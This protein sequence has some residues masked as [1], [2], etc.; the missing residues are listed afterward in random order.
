[1]NDEG[2]IHRAGSLKQSNKAYKS[3]HASKGSIKRKNKGRVDASLPKGNSLK[4]HSM[5][6]EHMSKQQRRS[7]SD[8]LRKQK[9]AAVLHQ[10][11]IGQDGAP[12]IVA[13]LS[14][15]EVADVSTIRELLIK[16]QSGNEG[17][18]VPASHIPF[19]FKLDTFKQRISVFEVQREIRT[20]L[21]AAKVADIIVLVVDAETG[22]D[23]SG[24]FL[25]NLIKGQG[26]PS[27]L[28]ILQNLE[29]LG[30]HK[31]DVK[32]NIMKWIHG[33]LPEEPRIV[34]FDSDKD[35]KQLSRWISEQT[36]KSIQWREKRPYMLIEN[37]EFVPNNAQSSATANDSSLDSLAHENKTGTLVV[38]GY[39]RGKSMTPNQLVN[40]VNYGTYQLS[41]IQ[42]EYDPCSL[43][44][45][46]DYDEKMKT[47][48]VPDPAKQESLQT[49]LQPDTS[50]N[51][52]T[53]PTAEDY[54]QQIEA[55]KLKKV[56]KGFSAY[57]AAWIP[58]DDEEDVEDEDEEDD[59]EMDAEEGHE[60]EQNAENFDFND[61]ASEAQTH[62]DKHFNIDDDEA[63]TEE[64]RLAERERTL[65]MIQ[66]SN[67][68]LEFPD[69]VATPL[70]E[71]ARVRFQK[72]RGLKSFRQSP[73]DSK[74]N[75][76]V[77]YS[78]IFQF[79]NFQRS[80][81]LSMLDPSE[82]GDEPYAEKENY[83]S[84][85]IADVPE[86]LVKTHEMLKNGPLVMFGL[87]RH[88]QKYSVLHF[89][90]K[91]N[92]E[93]TEPIK[94]KDELIVQV[95][96]RMFKC[97]PIYSEHNPRNDKH[98]FER[99]LPASTFLAASV[100]GPVTFRPAPVLM[101]KRNPDA[102]NKLDRLKLVATG[103]LLAVDPDRVM[104]KRI[105]L[106]GHPYKIHKK[107]GVV[108]YMFYNPDDIR[109]FKPVEL[110]TKHGRHGVIRESL[111][112]HG[113]MKCQFDNVVHQYDT[114][115]MNLYKR[116][117]PK[118][119]TEHFSLLYTP[120]S[121]LQAESKQDEMEA[122]E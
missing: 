3:K 29:K 16:G 38:R 119:T 52:Q 117:Y 59:V 49:S 30:K 12:K 48:L 27:S 53:W 55:K 84:F 70:D 102:T 7:R 58:D 77:D 35:V 50:M 31:N 51:E 99:F 108:R 39:L 43:K 90:I 96:F 78:R 62:V 75:L 23:E 71:P 113:L 72:Y 110:Y 5:S 41:K 122:D 112:T 106:T 56:P 68:E 95:G 14:L 109:W 114:I 61:V 81:K 69:E 60:E 42:Y 13:F 1:M 105:I 46:V 40:L 2:T 9:K 89:Q 44:K 32:K 91:K 121:E 54:K 97:N 107:Q 86:K 8:Q 98:K 74:E 21:D 88:E 45:S 79:E 26:M 67:E 18:T 57:Q 87:M 111:G 116:V 25:L 47:P 94:S 33:E 15:S 22:I 28:V 92:P 104:V 64:E 76:P 24:K 11:R 34:P 93:Y 63:M 36:A 120:T 65:K 118:W 73:W 103:A 115:C 6:G 100:F 101:F 80:Q 37:Y 19:T 66:E 20:V 83:F 82:Y 17:V 85:H 10:K 4:Q